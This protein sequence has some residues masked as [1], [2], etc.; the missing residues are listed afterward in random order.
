M[1]LRKSQRKRLSEF[2]F[3][4]IGGLLANPP[5]NGELKAAMLALATKEWQHPI[6]NIPVKYSIGSIERW[7]YLAKNEATDSVSILARKVRADKGIFHSLPEELRAEIRS[8]HT[9]HPTWSWLLHWEELLVK[10][11]KFSLKK[12]SYSTLKNYMQAHGMYRHKKIRGNKRD[13]AIKAKIRLE[14]V[15]TRSYEVEFVGG[16]WHLDFH[17]ARRQVLNEKA[18]W[19]T[20]IALGIIDDHSRLICHLQWFCQET[21][22]VLVHGFVQ[23]LEKRGLPRALMTD[24]GAAMVSAEFKEGLSRL[25]IFQEFTLPYS[26][27]QNGKIENLWVKIETRLMSMLENVKTLTLKELNFYSYA[28]V[29]REHNQRIHAET[30]DTPYHRFLN[31]KS[32]L[33]ASPSHEELINKFRGE[34]SRK[35]RRSDGTIMLEGIRYEIPSRFRNLSEV[36][37]QFAR[38]NP[39]NAHLLDPET[40]KLLAKIFPLDKARNANQHRATVLDAPDTSYESD[41][42]ASELLQK[43]MQEI[44]ATGMPCLLVPFKED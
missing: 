30:N 20:P 37:V 34:V 21:A 36:Y 33:R 15:E 44:A 17:H 32:V 19:I 12:T 26:P 25:G 1:S 39:T 42:K 16:L 23:A 28:W 7:Y 4:I 11:E 8:Q 24:N 38:W 27:Q 13:S 2:R 3:G 5:A 29:E 9:Q 18:E 40:G 35:Q 41:N 43:Y 6:K 31:A 22:E 10:C 14:K